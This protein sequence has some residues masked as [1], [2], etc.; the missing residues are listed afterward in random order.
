MIPPVLCITGID[1]DIGKTIVTG[2]LARYLHTKG[3]R[4]MTQ[5]LVQTG[6]VG[7]AEDILT[8]RTIMGLE[9]GVEDTSGLTCPYVF[10][11]ACSPHLAAE[12]EGVIIDST[13]IDCAT[14]A[15]VDRYE[16]VLVEGAGGL[17]VPLNRELMLLDYLAQKGWPLVLVSSPRL[18][19]INHTL[20]ALELADSRGLTVLGIVYNRFQEGDPRIVAD[21]AHVFRRALRQHG[22]NECVLDLFGLDVYGSDTNFP[23]FDCLFTAAAQCT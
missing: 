20:A 7:V 22:F 5:K 9:P 10:P 21:S 23:E 4:V 1:T 19:S 11:T 15:L 17:L 13:V 16:T 14:Q 18:G 8:H 2:L 3:L 12:I 6:C